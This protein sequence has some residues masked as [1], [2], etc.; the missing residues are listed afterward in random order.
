MLEKE[1]EKEVL[2]LSKKE[3]RIIDV[4]NANVKVYEK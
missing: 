4:L 2:V 3:Q 1:V